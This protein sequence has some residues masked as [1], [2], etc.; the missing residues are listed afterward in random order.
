MHMLLPQVMENQ[1][2]IGGMIAWLAKKLR[3]VDPHQFLLPKIV[4]RFASRGQIRETASILCKQVL[5]IL[6]FS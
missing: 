5:R 1:L 3:F 6:F 2:S 4:F